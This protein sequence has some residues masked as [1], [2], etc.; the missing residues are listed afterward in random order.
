MN[1]KKILKS[2]FELSGT[3]GPCH[4]EG[5]PDIK[6]VGAMDIANTADAWSPPMML[7][8][9]TESCFFLTLQAIAERM[10]VEIKSYSSEAEGLLSSPDGKH[11]Q[12]TEITIRPKLEVKDDAHEAKIPSLFKKAE[13]Y[14]YVARSLNVEIK[15]E[16]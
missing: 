5:H 3:G 2:S 8:A 12:F 7:L 6:V 10:R 4:F 16:T 1:D 11:T 15:I 9:A 14:C 13:E